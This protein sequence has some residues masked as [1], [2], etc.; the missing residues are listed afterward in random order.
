VLNIHG[1]SDRGYLLLNQLE[2]GA[3][4]VD[5]CT[6]QIFTDRIPA[7]IHYGIESNSLK[8]KK[9]KVWVK[10]ASAAVENSLALDP[11]D[12]SIFPNATLS[13]ILAH[14]LFQ[15]GYSEA[16]SELLDLGTDEIL[17]SQ[18]PQLV[19]SNYGAAI[20]SFE[21]S[22][23][24][25]LKKSSGQ[26]RICPPLASKVEVGDHII[27]I[28]KNDDSIVYTGVKTQVT[29]IH[30]RKKSVTK[31]IQEKQ[32]VLI[33]GWSHLGPALVEE[34][35]RQL[36]AGS[37]I[38]ILAD[39]LKCDS[40]TIPTKGVRGV[41]ISRAS[42]LSAKRFTHAIVLAYREDIGPHE[43]DARTVE[44]IRVLKHAI[45]A[46]QNLRIVAEFF[47]PAKAQ[48][49]QLN[50]ADSTFASEELAAKLLVQSWTNQDLE[51]V[52]GA[53]FAPGAFAISFQ[54]IENY[55]ES[56]RPITFARLTAAAATRGDSP[57]G[58]FKAADGMQVLINPSKAT[59]FDTKAGDKMIVI[60][61]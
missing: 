17:F 5:K 29:D 20:S 22:S 19:G 55:V 47:N 31:L 11:T 52:I 61:S 57:I 1:W 13:R 51:S 44:S 15:P 23:V 35:T 56:G 27:A 16:V 41:T 42:S 40:S 37:S 45:P 2:R 36:P 38:S 39:E 46:A 12:E 48:R 9:V 53:L 49:S 10:P 14:E 18:V 24:V 58:Y 7:D 54:P 34:L 32:V 3:K 21:R 4:K 43:A 50:D 25:G 8:L 30:A 33:V 59:I 26:I 6:V 28:A 60:S